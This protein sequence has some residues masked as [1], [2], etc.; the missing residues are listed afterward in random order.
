MKTTTIA[1][2][3]LPATVTPNCYRFFCKFLRRN[4]FDN[5]LVLDVDGMECTVPAGQVT[6]GLVDGALC[7]DIKERLAINLGLV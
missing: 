4:L 2:L 7:C 1:W 3:Q 6:V 5:T